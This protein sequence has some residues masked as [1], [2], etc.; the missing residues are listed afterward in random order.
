MIASQK[1]EKLEPNR[2]MMKH[3]CDQALQGIV[4]SDYL[5]EL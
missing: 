2:E 5:E 3:Y 1:M 4:F